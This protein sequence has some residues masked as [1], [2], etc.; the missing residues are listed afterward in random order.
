M[1]LSPIALNATKRVFKDCLVLVLG[2]NFKGQDFTVP[3]MEVQANPARQIKI[4]H[5]PLPQGV[6]VANLLALLN[7]NFVFF[8]LKE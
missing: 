1:P 7:L 5:R 6:V 3:I 8:A 4:L 2:C